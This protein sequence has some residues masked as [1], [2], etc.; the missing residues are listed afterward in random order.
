MRTSPVYEPEL[1]PIPLLTDVLPVPVD[2]QPARE[3]MYSTSYD[4]CTWQFHS[5]ST[6]IT[7]L[8]S[9]DYKH[10]VER[11][12]KK[13]LRHELHWNWN[14]ARMQHATPRTEIHTCGMWIGTRVQR[15][16]SSI[17]LMYILHLKHI[18]YISHGL[19]TDI[20]IKRRVSNNHL[21]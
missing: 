11:V 13:T 5:G 2:T 17:D 16:N 8:D 7:L 4:H 21:S 9:I 3:W 19:S 14:F 15:N 20:L 18:E 10:A 12:T 1:E 6:L